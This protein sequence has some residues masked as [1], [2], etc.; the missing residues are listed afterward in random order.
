MGLQTLMAVVDTPPPPLPSAQL[1]S[2]AASAQPDRTTTGWVDRLAQLGFRVGVVFLCV[3]IGFALAI[4]E[5]PLYQLTRNAFVAAQAL[6]AEYTL[7]GEEFSVYLWGKTRHPQVGLARFDAERASDGYTLYSSCH[8]SAVVALDIEGKEVHRWSAP[9][10]SVWSRAPQLARP[11]D[12]KLI[13]IRRFHPYPSG[14]LLAL[15]ETSATTPNG[16]GIARLDR[17][18]KPLWTYDANAHHDMT[19]GDDGRVFALTETVRAK[20]HPSFDGLGWGPQ[21]EEFVAVLSP[22]GKELQTISLFDVLG[23]SPVLRRVL[24]RSDHIGDIV[25][26]NSIH[27]VGPGFASQHAGVAPSDLMVCLR[28]LHLAVVIN[29]ERQEIVWATYGP[30]HF[31]H[32]AV[33]M[34]DGTILIFNNAFTRGKEVLSRVVQYDPRSTQTVWSFVEAEGTL[35]LRSHI[36]SNQQRLSNGNTLINESDG[37]RI[38]EVTHDGNVVW[39]FMNPAR[40]GKSGE[41]TAI[42]ARADRY[43]KD[44]LPFLTH[45]DANVPAHAASS[46][47]EN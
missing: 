13:Y 35:P 42:M 7:Q 26:S 23:K 32:D 17:D 38:L 34:P 6:I 8:E 36:R 20:P 28:N 2:P 29:I 10:S 9:F 4:A 18:G 14:D 22:E 40:G 3:Q 41:L 46:S 37:G 25:H 27:I 1:M 15:Y 12:D 21:I 19:V 45:R 47:K 33:P 39:E 43:A 44:R 16:C 31:P 11:V 30:W 5:S 24:T